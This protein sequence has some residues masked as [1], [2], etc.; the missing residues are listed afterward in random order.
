MTIRTHAVV[1]SCALALCMAATAEGPRPHLG[2]IYVVEV[3]VD[4][5][6][7]ID[8]LSAN[9]FSI[10]NVDGNRITIYASVDDLLWLK[11][12]GYDYTVIEQQ[13]SP[14][15]PKGGAK[16]LG[17]YHS[18]ADLTSALDA[19]AVAYGSGQAVHPDICRLVSLG[20]SAQ[21]RELWAMLITDNPDA[22]EFEPEFKYVGSIHGDEPVAAELCLYFIDYL[23]SHYGNNGRVTRAVNRT[24]I[25][26][27]PLMNPDGLTAGTRYN[28]NGID[29]NRAFPSWPS[30]FSGTLFDGA[31][32][33]VQG[34]QPEVQHIMQWTAENSFMLSANLHTG[35][36]LVNYPFDDDS[37]GSGNDAP[38][39]DDL[40]F[41]NIAERYSIHNTPMY[42]NSSPSFPKGIT[43]GSVWYQVDGGMQDWN[44]RY[45]A[46]NEVTIELSTTKAPSASAL[47]DLWDDN[48]ESMLAY[49]EA[50]DIGVRGLVR[51]K[52]TLE[53]VYAKVEVIGNAQPG[54]T[55][56][57]AGD[58]HRMLLPG[59]YTLKFS[60]PGYKNKRRYDVVVTDGRATRVNVKLKP[61]V[62][63]TDINGDGKV[64]AVDVQLVVASI[65]GESK[66]AYADADG[67]GEVNAD[68]LQIVANAV[69]KG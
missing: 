50:A 60:A 3:T 65:L 21:G 43:N 20:Q 12:D 63:K 49:L 66:S 30:E 56:P 2:P 52:V 45:A 23:L 55:D 18:Y 42:T 48:R 47:P 61:L 14:L 38:T 39:P 58:Y 31:P 62:V 13:P 44:Y 46:C 5:P 19:Y 22:E 7:E 10:G 36:L 8:A 32:V 24:A 6:A 35:A 16:A 4:S 51:D 59:T 34:R 29:L 57:D 41:E 68:D 40:L 33:D 37:K 69:C 25:W 11:V 17:Q 27:V 53:P 64:N 15:A 28:A 9:G 54:F 26:I 67:N 1:V